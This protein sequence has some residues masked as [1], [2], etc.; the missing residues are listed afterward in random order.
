[1]GHKRKNVAQDC[2]V[3]SVVVPTKDA[4]TLLSRRFTCGFCVSTVR[5]NYQCVAETGSVFVSLPVKSPDTSYLP[6][7]TQEAMT[8]VGSCNNCS[9]PT[10]FERTWSERATVQPDSSASA[11]TVNYGTPV[12]TI[13]VAANSHK[14]ALQSLNYYQARSSSSP[15]A[16]NSSLTL[17]S[18]SKV[19]QSIRSYRKDIG[20]TTSESHSYSRILSP[21]NEEEILTSGNPHLIKPQQT[22]TIRGHEIA[23]NNTVS[24]E[25]LRQSTAYM[26]NRISD[27]QVSAAVS[28]DGLKPKRN[29]TMNKTA[30]DTHGQKRCAFEKSLAKRCLYDVRSLVR[31]VPGRRAPKSSIVQHF[32]D[33]TVDVLS[34]RFPA[35][36][37]AVVEHENIPR[38]EQQ[39]TLVSFASP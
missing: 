7:C 31:Y 24:R 27:Q 20:L 6:K 34:E 15:E 29:N 12:L 38:V 21:L 1:M 16:S 37:V 5:Q 39:Y 26:P 25:M 23:K 4:Q 35:H 9:T 13:D 19:S 3:W 30:N 11:P 10:R 18:A 14:P 2:N 17:D 32:D 33:V 36:Y 8:N 28:R 22:T